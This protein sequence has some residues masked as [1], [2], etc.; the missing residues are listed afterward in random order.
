MK[1]SF[2]FM[3]L[4]FVF[5]EAM[6]LIWAIQ[7]EGIFPQWFGIPFFLAAT[8]QFIVLSIIFWKD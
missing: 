4:F 3:L 2:R 1:W 6:C 8:I 5:F 7:D